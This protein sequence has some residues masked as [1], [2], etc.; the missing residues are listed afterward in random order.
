MDVD[1]EAAAEGAERKKS[2]KRLREA[3]SRAAA[4]GD[5]DADE[6]RFRDGDFYISYVKDSNEN[7]YSEE[8][9]S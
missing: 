7:H 9:G 3:A 8:V 5:G 4:V 1:G 6:N 2:R